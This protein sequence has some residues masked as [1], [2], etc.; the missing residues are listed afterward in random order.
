MVCSFNIKSFFD[1]DNRLISGV[2]QVTVLKD[3][4]KQLSSHAYWTRVWTVQEVALNENCWVYL[5]RLKPLS[6]SGFGAM[7]YEVEGYMNVRSEET[8][9]PDVEYCYPVDYKRGSPSL[10]TILHRTTSFATDKIKREVLTH[11]MGKKAE[12][13]LDV[14]FACRALFPKSIGQMKVDYQRDVV[15]ILKEFTFRIVPCLEKLGDLLETVSHCPRITEAPTW[16]LN[17]TG[18]GHVWMATHFFGVWHATSNFGVSTPSTTNHHTTHRISSDMETLHVK[19]IILDHVAII[20]DEFPH[21]LLENQVTWHEKVRDMLHQ[22]R[23][24]T[25]NA[26]TI[27]FEK[28]IIEI[29]FAASTYMKEIADKASQTMSLEKVCLDLFI[30]VLSSRV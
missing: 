3:G 15:D 22:W 6:M 5:G 12:I 7:F 11:L 26:L 27:G 8:T 9:P 14:I 21:Y 23:T 1:D 19:G 2:E 13:P 24:C 18:G 25:Q 28:S 20:S 16:M 30:Y 29:L 17:I 10:A 4:L